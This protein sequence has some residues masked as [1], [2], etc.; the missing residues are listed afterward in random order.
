M[1]SI[2]SRREFISHALAG[3]GAT[4]AGNNCALNAS[5]IP[6]SKLKPPLPEH[7]SGLSPAEQQAVQGIFNKISA[8]YKTQ[9]QDLLNGSLP[10]LSAINSRL[11]NFI[12]EIAPELEALGAA[13]EKT[14]H[15]SGDDYVARLNS[16][17]TK[18]G[19]Y[20]SPT[21]S[22][23]GNGS[24]GLS[25][26]FARVEPLG[27]DLLAKE[28]LTFLGVKTAVPI[29]NV[30]HEFVPDLRHSGLWT[31]ASDDYSYG[32]TNSSSVTGKPT[33][34]LLFTG[35]ISRRARLFSV[36]PEDFLTV[37]SV[38]EFAN[39]ALRQNVPFERI[40][41][42]I[43]EKVTFQQ[44]SESY[45]DYAALRVSKTETFCETLRLILT[46]RNKNYILS[47][48]LVF[49]A[50][51]EHWKSS[52]IADASDYIDFMRSLPT[53][54]IDALKLNTLRAFEA[55]PPLQLALQGRWSEI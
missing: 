52:G 26:L 20:L 45:S 44:F 8:L 29:F 37:V 38:N 42:P 31:K 2:L 18:K 43:S 13:Q 12:A 10:P 32:Q 33:A 23:S 39:A 7:L 25:V 49:S 9:Q 17:L 16:L 19:L 24:Y 3:A 48:A 6:G 28:N 21:A 11:T 27:Q 14:K 30:K 41:K 53:A 5:E 15:A 35:N 50:I 40:S 4:F 36:A 55:F 46:S 22:P 54:E 47:K 34:I 1:P 51:G